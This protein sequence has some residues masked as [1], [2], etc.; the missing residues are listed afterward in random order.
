MVGDMLAEPL[1][2]VAFEVSR[3]RVVE[4]DVPFIVELLEAV[5]AACGIATVPEHSM[6]GA[7]VAAVVTV[8]E[9][10]A[11]PTVE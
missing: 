11:V 8:P 6:A 3:G 2:V 1:L 7:V 9:G 5:T 4:I 10:V